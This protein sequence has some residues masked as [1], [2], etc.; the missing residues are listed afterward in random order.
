M[1]G[2]V[3]NTGNI[4][5]AFAALTIFH[6]LAAKDTQLWVDLLY[7]AGGFLK[8]EKCFLYFILFLWSNKGRPSSAS[9][10]QLP[11]IWIKDPAT[12]TQQTITAV[13]VGESRQVLGTELNPLRNS[14]GQF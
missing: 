9:T 10:H 2:F 1:N 7:S 8:L 4:T 12:K 3:D 14:K 13:A 11:P 6:T 5:L